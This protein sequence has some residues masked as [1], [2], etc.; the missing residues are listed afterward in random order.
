MILSEASEKKIEQY[1]K[2]NKMILLSE[3]HK[4]VVIDGI[5]TIEEI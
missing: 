1:A 3:K 4:K 2:K 5:T